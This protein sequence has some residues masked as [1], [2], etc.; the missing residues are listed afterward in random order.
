LFA[1]GIILFILYSGSPPFEKALPT[2]AYYKVFS[3]KNYQVFW[4]AHSKK[5]PEGFYPPEFKNLI[6]RMLCPKP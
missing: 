2:D 5:K 6:E 4:N 3:N 1:A